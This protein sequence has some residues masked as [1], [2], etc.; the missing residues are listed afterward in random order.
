MEGERVLYIG[1]AV[2]QILSELF[3]NSLDAS[4]KAYMSSERDSSTFVG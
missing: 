3:L 1:F 2:A 4:G